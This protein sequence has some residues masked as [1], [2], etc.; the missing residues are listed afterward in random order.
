[1]KMKNE[2]M[3]STMDDVC[4]NIR[5]VNFLKVMQFKQMF[6]TAVSVLFQQKKFDN[7]TRFFFNSSQLGVFW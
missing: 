6:V 2:M 4:C 7:G 3:Y 5:N 1:M